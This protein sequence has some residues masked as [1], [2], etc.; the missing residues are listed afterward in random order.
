MAAATTTLA[1]I[2][3]AHDQQAIPAVSA[4]LTSN[5]LSSNVNSA[6]AA[7][8][9]VATAAAHVVGEKAKEG[10]RV[11]GIHEYKEAAA[12]LAD[13][14]KDDHT[15]HYFLDTPDS[16]LTAAQKWDIHVC[17][18]EY[19]TYAHCMKGLVTT[20]GPNYDAVALW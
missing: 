6:A 20:V 10:V 5:T 11:V 7:D 2:Q 12:C 15:T 3:I 14:F 17:M 19:I 18:M 9:N 4:I 16:T 13:A 1:S 8:A